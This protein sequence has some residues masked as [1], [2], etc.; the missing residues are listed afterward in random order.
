MVPSWG[1]ITGLYGEAPG[2]HVID[3]IRSRRTIHEWRP[4][5]I[6][7]D[8]LRRALDAAVWAPNHHLTEPWEF[9]VCTGRTKER[10]ADIRRRLKLAGAKDTNSEQARRSG[11]RAYRE[12]ADVAAA[13]MVTVQLVPDPVRRREDY[14]ATCCAIQNF[15]LAAWAEGIGTYWGTGPVTRDPEAL[16]MLGIGPDRE[17][18]GLVLCGK[19]ALTPEAR[20]T[21]ASAKTRWM[22]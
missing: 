19:P 7:M 21:P 16:S 8:A 14:A 6:D 2:L 13:I 9:I 3:A 17:V 4:G 15:M 5:P 22:D 20:R 11:E 1:G 10:L 18:V 12:V